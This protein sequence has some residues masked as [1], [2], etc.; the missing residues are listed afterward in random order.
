MPGSPSW[1]AASLALLAVPTG[2][3]V[4]LP[5]VGF[6]VS[7][8]GSSLGAALILIVPALM[9]RALLPGAETGVMAG[10]AG[11]GVLIGLFGTIVTFLESYTDMLN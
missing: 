8:M 4:V 10:V 6:V 5:D 9:G 2:L 7:L 3:A 1:V 11:F